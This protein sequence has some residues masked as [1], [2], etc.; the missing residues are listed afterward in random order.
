[1]GTGA[2]MSVA[3]RSKIPFNN[4]IDRCIYPTRRGEMYGY[5]IS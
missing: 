4:T 5:T 1:M 3:K 2:T